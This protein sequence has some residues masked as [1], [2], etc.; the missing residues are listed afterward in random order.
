MSQTPSAAYRLRNAVTAE[1]P[2][3]V[4]GTINAFAARLAEGA[5]FRALYL[6]GAGVAGA[7]LGLSRSW[8]F[9][10]RLAVVFGRFTTDF[11]MDRL[12]VI[13]GEVPKRINTLVVQ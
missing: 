11:Q 1:K 12:T 6:S 10:D 3:Q 4:A 9:Q 8:E 13:S 7:S 5:G 2:L